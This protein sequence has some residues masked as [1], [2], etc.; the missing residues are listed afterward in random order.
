MPIEIK[1]EDTQSVPNRNKD[2]F[3]TNNVSLDHLKK[4]ESNIDNHPFETENCENSAIDLSSNTAINSTPKPAPV[5]DPNKITVSISDNTTPIVVLYGPPA[6]GKTM[7]L[8]RLTRFL[9]DIGYTITPDKVFRGSEDPKYKE[10]CD[11]FDEIIASND[12][13]LSTDRISFMLVKVFF[14][15]H[16]ICQILEAPGEHYYNP[17]TKETN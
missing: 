11:D 6:C 13:A 4:D 1:N 5:S 16:P 10:L 8:V 14:N 17:D 15:G 9:K 12:A 2:S 7:T 3:S